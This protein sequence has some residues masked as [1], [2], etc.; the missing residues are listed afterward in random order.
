MSALRQHSA[1]KSNFEL[2]IADALVEAIPEGEVVEY[3]K[4]KIP[5]HYQATKNYI[6]DFSLPNGIYVEAKGRWT[7]PDRAKHLLVRRQHPDKDIRL[8][9][10]SDNKLTKAKNGMRYSDFCNKYGIKFII[11]KFPKK[12]KADW[13]DPIKELERWVAEK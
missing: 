12:P 5:Y 8:I 11:W 3:E 6:P 1:L 13:V 10:Q 9:F 4:E 2:K 7:A